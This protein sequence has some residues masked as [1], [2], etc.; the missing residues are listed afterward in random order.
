[1]ERLVKIPEVRS[2]SVSSSYGLKT[3]RIIL[4]KRLCSRVM[5]PGH[6]CTLRRGFVCELCSENYARAVD[7]H[8]V[9]TGQTTMRV[10]LRCYRN[11]VFCPSA[12]TDRISLRSLRVDF[13]FGMLYGTFR[14]TPIFET[15]CI[16]LINASALKLRGANWWGRRVKTWDYTLCFWNTVN[17]SAE[18]ITPL[19]M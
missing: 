11:I 2:V 4:F 16:G 19:F 14:T 18:I 17:R 10:R 5:R 9:R 1:M 7:I 3:K 15:L 6:E 12:V 8:G 13:S